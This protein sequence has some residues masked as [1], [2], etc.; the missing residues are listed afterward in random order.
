M[1]N[2]Y[3]D[4]EDTTHV[5]INT[6]PSYHW[7][8]VTG[9]T[10]SGKTEFLTNLSKELRIAHFDLEHG[11]DPYVGSFLKASSFSEFDSK[12]IW[13]SENIATIKP[14]I[15]AIDPLDKLVDMIAKSY[16]A[17]KGIENLSE[18]PYGQGW[19]DTRDILQSRMNFMFT[20][21]PLVITVTHVKLSILDENRKNITYLDMDLPGKTK[22]WV[23]TTADAH[24]IFMRDKDPE[25]ESYLKVSVDLS[26][27]TTISFGG[28]R[29]KSFYKIHLVEELIEEI[30]KKFITNVWNNSWTTTLMEK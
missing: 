7:I 14:D 11:T 10:K 6:T 26:S 25:G 15:I 24:A 19:S 8:N 9:F 16:M 27:P 4:T 3:S 29:V 21:A 1:I 17:D 13:L 18:M 20:L 23:Q 22:A 28:C 30:K 2:I 12:L 5:G